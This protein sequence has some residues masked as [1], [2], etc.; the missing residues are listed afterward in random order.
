MG[1]LGVLFCGRP[2]A[3]GGG[4]HSR[5]QTS[6]VIAMIIPITV[7]KTIPESIQVQLGGMV[8]HPPYDVGG[9]RGR[10]KALS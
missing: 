9:A 2:R 8:N 3:D 5:D 1:L 10:A 6:L 4:D 7:K